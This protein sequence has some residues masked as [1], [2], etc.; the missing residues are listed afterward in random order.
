MLKQKKKYN[1]PRKPFE[2]ARIDEEAGIVKV[3][4]LKNKRE[5]WKA[6]FFISNI[7]SQA[8][9]LIVAS[10]EKQ[11]KFIENLV[12]VG[13][14][15]EGAGIDDILGLK[16]ENLLDR[17]LQTVVFRKGMAKTAKGARQ[18]ITH[19]H[20]MISGKIVDIPS[21][22]VPVEAEKDILLKERKQKKKKEAVI[23]GK[24]EMKQENAAESPAEEKAMENV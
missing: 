13:L 2:K 9:D 7:R 21:Y 8:K 11:K 20:V 17:R 23:E 12:K 4:G 24:I 3:Y 19:K 5:I 15:K 6:E 16:K 18:L 1:R 10:E 22:I 14:V